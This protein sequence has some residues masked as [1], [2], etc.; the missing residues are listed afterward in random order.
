MRGIPGGLLRRLLDAV[1]HPFGSRAPA[2][3]ALRGAYEED[4]EALAE[5][6]GHLVELIALRTALEPQAERVRDRLLQ[7]SD[8]AALAR[9]L[10]P[11][12][13]ATAL[14]Q[15]EAARAQLR[16]LTDGLERMRAQEQQLARRADDLRLGAEILAAQI[17]RLEATRVAVAAS[18]D[19]EAAARGFSEQV[20]RTRMLLDQAQTQILD[21]Q[22]RAEAVEELLAS[23][24]LPGLPGLDAEPP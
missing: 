20:A 21:L 22:A 14:I 16:N 24:L 15:A 3:L 17:E 1:R 10:G 8:R 23:G 19:V 4:L 5:A 6:R 12:E 7:L 13:A 11:E 18:R 2:A 9:R